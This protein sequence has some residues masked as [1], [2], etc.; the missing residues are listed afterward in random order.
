[1][2]TK[3]LV[4]LLLITQLLSAQDSVNYVNPNRVEVFYW[5]KSKKQIFAVSPMSKRIESVN[6]LALGFGHV[7]NKMV[8]KQTINGLNLEVNPAP[9]PGAFVAF[10]TLMYLPEILRKNHSVYD[11][12]D[13]KNGEQLK[14]Q[15]WIHTP[16]LQVNGLNVSSGCFFTTTSMNGLNISLGNKFKD[17]N[18]LSI[19]PLGTISNNHSGAAIGF[20]NANNRLNGFSIGILNQSYRL[21]GVHFGI[22]NYSKTNKGL[23]VGVFNK[24]Y[25]KG[26]Q[27]GLWNVNS[28]RKLPLLNW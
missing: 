5:I 18:G 27:L 3:I 11:V 10:M 28:K 14:I 9:I 8:A 26:F 6:G 2:K 19:A 24:S 17:F 20:Y 15:N 13:I 22:V 4:L 7:E 1:M 16:N 21:N 23:Q 25:S 12:K